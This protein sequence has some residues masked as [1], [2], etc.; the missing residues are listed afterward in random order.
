M[1][2]GQILSVLIEDLDAGVRPVA[3]EQPASFVH[4]DAVRDPELARC[5]SG[6]APGLDELPVL[7]E[8]HDAVVRAMAVGDEDVAIGSRRDAGRGIE[9]ALVVTGDARL[10]ER[11]QQLSVRAE[12]A[13]DV[14][15]PDPG[16]GGSCD[17]LVGRRV[18]RPHIALAIDMQAVRPDEHLRAEAF[19]D[20]ALGVE[21]VDRVVGLERSVGVHAVDAEPAAPGERHRARLIASDKGPDT[22][23]VDVNMD[24]SRR[25][26]LA[27][28]RK[29]CPFTARDAGAA[30]IRQSPDG[31]VWVIGRS[32]RVA[33]G[34]RGKHRDDATQHRP[35]GSNLPST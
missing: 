2:P 34:A 13:H 18:G 8:L 25:S 11:H 22:F 32:L 10:A 7:R 15:G 28:A 16:L 27:A 12:L 24:R 19:D 29:S 3:H 6:L 17:G 31:A 14:P 35:S 4:R 1:P 20:V 5:V 33:H 26:H 23:S 9:M 30:S 21:L